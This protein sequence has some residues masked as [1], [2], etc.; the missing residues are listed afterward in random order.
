M[1]RDVLPDDLVLLRNGINLIIEHV[2]IVIEGIVLLLSLDKGGH[3]LLCVLD[4][5]R[6]GNLM[7]G[8]L[9]DF[10]VS[11]VGIHEALLLFVIVGPF[12]EAELEQGRG[13]SKFCSPGELFSRVFRSCIDGNILLVH[14]S[15]LVTIIFVFQAFLKV[16]EL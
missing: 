6:F 1:L 4:T 2:D 16:L 7:K 12:C 8:I 14:V 3:D 13:V 11:G 10:N 9:D 15:Y 5:R